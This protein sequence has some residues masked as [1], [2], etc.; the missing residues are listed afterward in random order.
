ME[1]AS[2]LLGCNLALQALLQPSLAADS[3]QADE[4]HGDNLRG[5]SQPGTD[6]SEPGHGGAGGS[7]HGVSDRWPLRRPRRGCP[8]AGARSE[9]ATQGPQ[10]MENGAL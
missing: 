4:R 5:Q 8:D 1:L 9:A 2:P 7:Y 3:Q 6:G 10:V